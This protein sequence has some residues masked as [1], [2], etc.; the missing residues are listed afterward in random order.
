MQSYTVLVPKPG[1]R[2]ADIIDH[3]SG[4]VSE[5][6]IDTEG[7]IE[8]YFEGNRHGAENLRTYA[9][10]VG[11]AAG[12][13]VQRYP[14]IA[15]ATCAS[16]DF[17]VVG[18]YLFTHDWS[19]FALKLTDEATALD[20]CGA[21]KGDTRPMSMHDGLRQVILEMRSA[22]QLSQQFGTPVADQQL[23]RNWADQL[24]TI[25]MGLSQ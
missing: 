18:R 11:S 16:D 10:R 4:I 2:A 12:R 15:R 7:R 24:A 25:A 1:T 5:G 23:I 22:V 8:V 17:H 19:T 14:T 20:W 6:I 13:L 3:G 21:S 9:Q